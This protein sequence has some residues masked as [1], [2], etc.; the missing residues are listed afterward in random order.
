[1]DYHFDFHRYMNEELWNMLDTVSSNT[2]GVLG[3][4]VK[5]IKLRK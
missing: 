3:T 2:D 1:M 5:L 4:V